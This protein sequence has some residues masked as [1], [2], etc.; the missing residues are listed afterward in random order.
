MHV[1]VRRTDKILFVIDT[2]QQV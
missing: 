2:F 1:R